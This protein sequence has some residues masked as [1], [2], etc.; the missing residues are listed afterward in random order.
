MNIR[1]QRPT[2]VLVIA[3]LSLLFGFSFGLQGCMGKGMT[4]FWAALE[5]N[6]PPQMQPP[7]PGDPNAP[8]APAAGADPMML[9]QLK[10][11]REDPS[12]L[13]I[14]TTFLVAFVLAGVLQCVAGIGLIMMKN[15]GRVLAILVALVILVTTVGN[16]TYELIV[17]AP[18]EMAMADIVPA[19]IFNMKTM[20]QMT[21][22]FRVVGPLPQLVL[23][24]VTIYYLTRK[25]I[26][27]AFTAPP[28]EADAKVA[29][30][31]QPRPA[32]A[33]PAAGPRMVTLVDPDERFRS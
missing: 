31:D 6:L 30:L 4:F 14:T 3:I 13:P 15:W 8:Q 32:E 10:L 12:F 5:K 24:A 16:V 18:V 23:V 20:P 11:L 19:M 17:L 33:P 29:A 28:T 27:A 2:S 7:N 25:D 1:R 26:K 22:F 21:N 9:A